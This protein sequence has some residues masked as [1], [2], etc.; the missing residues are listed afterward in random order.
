M[1]KEELIREVENYV[2]YSRDNLL[3]CFI[4]DSITNDVKKNNQ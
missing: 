4:K 3:D 1:N 2:L